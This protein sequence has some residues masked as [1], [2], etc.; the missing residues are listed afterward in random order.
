MPPAKSHKARKLTVSAVA[1]LN[2]RPFLYG[3]ENSHIRE[4][5]ALS[6]DI[7]AEGYRKL[8]HGEAD[9]GLV[10]VA[11][12][13]ELLEVQVISDYCI[14]SEG[15]VES[16]CIF[17]EAPIEQAQ[18]VLM[19]YQSRTSVLLSKIL[20]DHYWGLTPEI[21]PGEKG[22]E[23]NIRDTT[24][25]LV[26]GDRAIA[27]RA[28]YPYRYDLATCWKALTGLPMVFAIWVSRVPLQA[29]FIKKWK[30]ALDY[31]LENRAAVIARIA[32]EQPPAFELT[33]YLTENIHFRLDA[34]KQE[35]LRKFLDLSAEYVEDSKVADLLIA[36]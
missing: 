28:D 9:I 8:L 23:K 12:L 3:L 36:G 35:G 11:L 5:L 16:V 1:Y 18:K 34:R 29:A 6:L 4:Q 27:L 2:T 30:E 17:S 10:P 25:G 26:I 19:D 7:P 21:L 32:R 33:R 24:A 14:A 15:P 31:G 13:H 22:F 20:L